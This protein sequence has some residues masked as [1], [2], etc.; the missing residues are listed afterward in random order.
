M[1]NRLYVWFELRVIERRTKMVQ[2]KMSGERKLSFSCK[3]N[4]ISNFVKYSLVLIGL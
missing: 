2:R 1:I 4:L 3:G